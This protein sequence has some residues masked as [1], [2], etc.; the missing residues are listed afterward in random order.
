MHKKRGTSMKSSVGPSVTIL[1]SVIPLRTTVSSI[2]C[3][4]TMSCSTGPSGTIVGS[5]VPLRMIT[6]SIG[7]SGTIV[8]SVF[9]SLPFVTINHKKWLQKIN[10]GPYSKVS[11]YNQGLMSLQALDTV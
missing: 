5:V 11:L 10:I 1:C 3:L 7:P 8:C 6:S 4:G 9:P 2:H